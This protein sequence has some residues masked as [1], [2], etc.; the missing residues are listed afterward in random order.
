MSVES[1][2]GSSEQATLF[3]LPESSSLSLSSLCT[4]RRA[5]LFHSSTG[6]IIALSLRSPQVLARGSEVYLEE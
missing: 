5:F 6:A 2:P 3:N 1:S 4:W